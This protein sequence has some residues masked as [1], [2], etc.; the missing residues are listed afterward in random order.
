MSDAFLGRGQAQLIISLALKHSHTAPYVIDEVLALAAMHLSMTGS[1]PSIPSSSPLDRIQQPQPQ[2]IPNLQNLATEMQ[3]RA[4]AAFTRE[5]EVLAASS[6]DDMTN[7]SPRF[8]FSAM[9]SLHVLADCLT[10]IA[11][12]AAGFHGFIDRFVECIG[13]QRGVR[14][15]I[16]PDWRTLLESELR[17][18]LHP[19][20]FSTPEY[21]HTQGREC[22]PLE[23]LMEQ[24]DLSPASVAACKEAVKTLQWAFDWQ[25]NYEDRDSLYASS[26][27]AIVVSDDF[28]DILR[29]H[30]PEALIIMAYYGVM[31]H[32]ARGFWAFGPSGARIIRAVADN[33][34]SFWQ[35]AMRWPLHVLAT[36]ND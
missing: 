22:E 16:K 28:A 3:T 29:K 14:A 18:I 19:S 17:P 35:N 11:D 9:L 5:T 15:V 25:N 24:S 6:A 30:R 12:P 1:P 23:G 4:L 32:R 34:G 2:H 10:R 20:V 33:L 36:E 21:R 13:L 26:G 7:A 27:F 31:L 8:L